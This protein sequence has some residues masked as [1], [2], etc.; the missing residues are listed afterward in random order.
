MSVLFSRFFSLFSLIATQT[1]PQTTKKLLIHTF[2]FP[3]N[4]Y[5]NQNPCLCLCCALI[6]SLCVCINA[7]CQMSITRITMGTNHTPQPNKIKH[8]Y[9]DQHIAHVCVLPTSCSSYYYYHYRTRKTNQKLLLQLLLLHIR[10]HQMDM[11]T[12]GSFYYENFVSNRA[13][14]L[15]SFISFLLSTLVHF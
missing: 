13:Y 11:K 10:T 6:M 14:F 5:P 12:M 4:Y 1:R 8:V 15:V 2:H 7:C 3:T 9:I